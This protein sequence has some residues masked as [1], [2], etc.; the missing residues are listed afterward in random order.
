MYLQTVNESNFLLLLCVLD[1]IKSKC[2]FN[3]CKEM[4][5]KIEEISKTNV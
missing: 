2:L 5:K 3:K 4:C 1:Q